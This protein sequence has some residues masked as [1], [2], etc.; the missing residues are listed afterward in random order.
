VQIPFDIIPT[1]GTNVTFHITYQNGVMNEHSTDVVLP[2][3]FGVDKSAVVPV[4]NDLALVDQGGIYELTGDVT[5]AGITDANG[6]V[7]MVGPPAV[8]QQPYSNYAVGSLTSDDFSSFTLTFT[9]NDLSNV[10]II[11]QWKDANGNSLSSTTSFDLRSLVAYGTGGTRSSSGSSSAA[12]G[13]AAGS[14]AAATGGAGQYRGGGGL[15][16][17][18]GGGGRGGGLASF[19]PV[20][21]GGIILVIAIVLWMKRKW[22]LAKLKKQ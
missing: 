2:L 12:G 8:P 3:N 9:A 4:I 7:L 20:I 5:N 18:F 10:P 14:S 22:I 21:A 13:S 15:G 17:I 6:L 11:T 16:G 19:Y 1:T